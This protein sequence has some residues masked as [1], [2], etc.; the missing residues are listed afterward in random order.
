MADAAVRAT[1]LLL[2][3]RIPRRYV[4]RP[5]AV[6]RARSR[7]TAAGA[8]TQIAVHE[9]DTP[10]TPEPHV[11]LLGGHGYSVLLTNAGSG[12]SR[13]NGIDVLR[14][15]ADA[16]RDD[17]GQWIYIK[18][19]TAGALWSAAYQPRARRRRRIARR[20]RPIGSSSRGAMARWTRKPKSSSSPASKPRSAA[21]RSST[22]RMSTRE[23]ELT[24]YGEVVLCP[25]AAD[26]AHPAFQKLFVE[27]EWVP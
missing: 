4:P 14:W 18:D 17:T 9:V 26:R 20:S 15:R 11:A 3:E 1:A 21:S 27:T 22:G 8:A 7:S 16:T 5:R 24:S 2:D 12:H 13:A 10:H 6:R 25:A 23:L 19:L